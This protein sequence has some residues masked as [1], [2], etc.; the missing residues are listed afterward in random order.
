MSIELLRF[1]TERLLEKQGRL[2]KMAAGYFARVDKEIEIAER[3]IREERE[4]SLAPYAPPA[5]SQDGRF[6]PAPGTPT[7]E[8]AQFARNKELMQQG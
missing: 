4:A 2:E 3:K 8:R 1:Q 5:R 6:E 7:D